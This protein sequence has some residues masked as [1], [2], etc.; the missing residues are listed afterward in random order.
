LKLLLLQNSDK[1]KLSNIGF[2]NIPDV[3]KTAGQ[4]SIDLKNGSYLNFD[5]NKQ[6]PKFDVEQLKSIDQSIMGI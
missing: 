1:P 4:N 3:S 6:E 2:K 5:S